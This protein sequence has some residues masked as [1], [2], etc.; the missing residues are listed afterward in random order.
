MNVQDG[1]FVVGGVVLLIV[2]ILIVRRI[3][4]DMR[5]PRES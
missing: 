2:V 5:G 4:Q 3:I 1:A